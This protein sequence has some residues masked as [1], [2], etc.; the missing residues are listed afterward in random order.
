MCEKCRARDAQKP[1]NRKKL[2]TI[3]LELVNMVRR[4]DQDA[5]FVHQRSHA[6]LAER[7]QN[8]IEEMEAKYQP[9]LDDAKEKYLAA[10]DEV[11]I[12]LG[13][14]PDKMRDV[15]MTIDWVSGDVFEIVDY[16]EDNDMSP[17]FKEFM[18]EL[19][20]D[21]GSPMAQF[22]NGIPG[23]NEAIARKIKER[24]RR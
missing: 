17:S 11:A 9:Q 10:W 13:L 19:M 21:K 14:D 20:A 4:A 18:N 16:T 12:A 22:I 2:G 3:P 5:E 23:L 7:L 6:E 15:Q 8:L 1:V 24:S